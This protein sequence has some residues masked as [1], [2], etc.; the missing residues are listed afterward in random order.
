VLRQILVSLALMLVCL[1]IQILAL[2]FSVR[3]V[4]KMHLWT[5]VSSHRTPI[6]RLLAPMFLVLMTSHNLQV[7]SWA[8]FY[9]L[10][11]SFE[12]AEN[13]V[14][15]SIVSYTTLGFGD[16]LLPSRWRLLG[17]VE[18]MT[19]MLLLGWSTAFSFL[20]L[21]KLGEKLTKK[22]GDG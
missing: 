15:F 11:A 7:I 5:Q 2:S 19:G 17:G 18:A 16:L 10:S 20:V 22:R 14:Y 6:V 13:A 9:R 1:G 8:L 4:L 3:R 21:S 12:T